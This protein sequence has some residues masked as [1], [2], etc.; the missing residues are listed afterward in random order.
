MRRTTPAALVV[1]V[2][3]GA[4]GGWLVELVLTQTARPLL[5]PPLVFSAI[6]VVVAA[7]VVLVAVPV[8]RVAR[9][10][11]GARVDPFLAARVAVF[12]QATALTAAVLLGATAAVLGY[13]LTRPVIGQGLLWPSILAVVAAAV[14]LVAALVAEE[15]CR[16]PP[17]EDGHHEEDADD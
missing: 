4:L 5:T 3:V 12:A 16:I 10:R 2:A 13:L 11:P 17:G 8:R 1:L 9:G 6:V 14:L 15:M 7:G